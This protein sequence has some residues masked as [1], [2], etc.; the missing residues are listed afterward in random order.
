MID[1]VK[2]EP[3]IRRIIED[4]KKKLRDARTET[5]KSYQLGWV[6]AL[7]WILDET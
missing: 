1:T 3:D 4:V 2:H 6:D 7:L 5:A